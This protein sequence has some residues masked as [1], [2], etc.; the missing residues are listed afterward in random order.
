M[1]VKH[2]DCGIFGFTD[3][4]ICE[5]NKAPTS[6]SVGNHKPNDT[7]TRGKD[8]ASYAPKSALRA[9]VELL[10]LAFCFQQCFS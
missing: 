8:G 1:M 2:I 10:R 3:C 5:M 7:S 6:T 9:L 4:A